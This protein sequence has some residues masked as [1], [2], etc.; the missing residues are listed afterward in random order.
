LE[1]K[2]KTITLT[3]SD[4]V[5]I[6]DDWLYLDLLALGPWRLSA[7]GYVQ[8]CGDVNFG[9]CFL[10]NIVADFA[11]HKRGGL[12]VDHKSRNKLDNRIANLRLATSRQQSMNRGRRRNN[13][14]GLIGVSWDKHQQKWHARIK[15]DGRRKHLGFFDDKVE[16]ARARD[17]AILA[18]PDAQFAVL[19]F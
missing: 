3:N 13:T 18:A 19:N 17:A 2:L 11:G 15:V 5:A 4:Q 16:A 7:D 1:V 6:V 12:T 8:A 14:S 9:Y 10:H